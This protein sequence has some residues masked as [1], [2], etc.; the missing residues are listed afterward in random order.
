[1]IDVGAVFADAGCGTCHTLR[2]AG[3]SGQ[4]GP[5]LDALQ[6]AYGQILTQVTKGGGG[7]PAYGGKL[8][9]AQIRDLA[10]FVAT[11][12]GR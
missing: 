11:R 3:A 2:A 6:P 10:A 12:A 4:I 7:M 8:T 5:N 1:M 9:A